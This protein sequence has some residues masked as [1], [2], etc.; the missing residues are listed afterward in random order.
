MFA[1]NSA[2]VFS[3]TEHLS[4]AA[5]FPKTRRLTS[6]FLEKEHIVDRLNQ[7]E[8]EQHSTSYEQFKSNSQS[9]SHPSA[10]PDSRFDF[11]SASTQYAPKPR[12]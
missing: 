7:D 1:L 8:L 10:K 5:I 4:T 6:Y 12:D 2:H 11:E 3:N 9:S